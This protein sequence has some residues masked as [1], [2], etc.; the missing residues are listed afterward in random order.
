MA[1]SRVPS[2]PPTRADPPLCRV[3]VFATPTPL[4]R[5]LEFSLRPE[6]PPGS[7]AHVRLSSRW[8]GSLPDSPPGFYTLRL[9]TVLRYTAL[10]WWWL[11]W[12]DRSGR[13][14]RVQEKPWP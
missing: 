14:W 8:G 4:G 12:R 7:V 6:C 9:G 11:D 10:N 3:Q 5:R 2:P 13:L 1:S